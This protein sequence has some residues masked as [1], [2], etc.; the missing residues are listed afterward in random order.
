MARRRQLEPVE[1]QKERYLAGFS[2]DCTLTAGCRA[3]A[4]SPGT[5]YQWRETDV[6]FVM[7]ENQLRAQLAD[8]L[9]TEAIRRGRDGWDRPIYQRGELVGAERIFSDTLLKMMLGALRPAKFREQLHVSGAVEQIVQQVAGLRRTRGALG[10]HHA[11]V[12]R[13]WAC[14]ST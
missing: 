12:R 8:S 4:V 10:W 13:R 3:D 11:A 2:V 9:E 1:L 6:A 5:V 14:V 7:R